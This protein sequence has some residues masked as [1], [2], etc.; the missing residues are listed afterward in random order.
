LWHSCY[1]LFTWCRRATEATTDLVQNLNKPDDEVVSELIHA[2]V[3]RALTRRSFAS[4]V[5]QVSATK[6]GKCSE[7]IVLGPPDYTSTACGLQ[8]HQ[9]E[10]VFRLS[11][12]HERRRQLRRRRRFHQAALLMGR[13]GRRHRSQQA[14]TTQFPHDRRPVCPLFAHALVSLQGRPATSGPSVG[15]QP[16]RPVSISCCRCR[17]RGERRCCKLVTWSHPHSFQR[18]VAFARHGLRQGEDSRRT[19]WC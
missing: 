8:Q 13:R 18:E 7:R 10:C 14:A 6:F 4:D 17:G 16:A 12:R 3:K 19:L 11:F 1:K 5:V 9:A 15:R 2:L